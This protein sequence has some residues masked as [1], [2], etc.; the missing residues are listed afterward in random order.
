[1]VKELLNQLDAGQRQVRTVQL[2][3]CTKDAS[4]AIVGFCP[5]KTSCNTTPSAKRS[6]ACVGGWEKDLL[7]S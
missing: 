4:G 6:L 5:V 2:A 1:M 7:S 3:N